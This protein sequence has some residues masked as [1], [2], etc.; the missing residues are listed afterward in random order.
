MSCGR[1]SDEVVRV[2]SILWPCQAP[3][4]R[5]ITIERKPNGAVIRADSG[6]V[7]IGPGLFDAPNSQCVFHTGVV[8]AFHNIR[9]IRDT[10]QFVGVAGAK[11]QAVYFDTDIAFENVRRGQNGTGLLT[12]TASRW[13]SSGRKTKTGSGFVQH[14]PQGV[15]ASSR[16]ARRTVCRSGTDRRPC[17]LRARRRQVRPA[18]AGRHRLYQRRSRSAAGETGVCC[19][20]IRLP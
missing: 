14:E 6:W 12:G 17:G 2:K 13:L 18:H 15:L 4:V 1:T 5:E 20:G 8:K 3:L 19:R 16:S 10:R 7:A 9:E 11:F